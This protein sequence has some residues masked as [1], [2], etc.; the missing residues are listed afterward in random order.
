MGL[1]SKIFKPFKKIVR[2][3]GGAIKSVG[4]IIAKPLKAV[5]KPIGKFFGKLGPIGTIALGFLLPGIGGVMGSWLQGAGSAFQGLFQGMPK[6]FNAI[7]KIGN[8]IQSAAKWGGDLYGKTVG[9]VFDSIS[10]AIKGGVDWL[11]NGKATD[12]GNWCKTFTEK[13]SYKG[14]GFQKLNAD[15]TLSAFNDVTDA[16]V[17]AT[18]SLT[19]EPVEVTAQYRRPEG[20]SDADFTTYKP[21]AESLEAGRVANLESVKGPIREG[22][23][24]VTDK[25][26]AVQSSTAGKAYDVYSTVSSYLP[27]DP[28]RMRMPGTQGA[29]AFSMLGNMP[30]AFGSSDN[31][32][33]MDTNQFNNSSTF[34]ELLGKYAGGFG[35]TLTPRME[36]PFG[37]VNGL[38]GYAYTPEDAVMSGSGGN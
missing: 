32:M 4:K 6:I 9:H 22:V 1:L 8:A 16:A 7:G 38:G 37:F 18:K 15:G 11:T 5:L 35:A 20:M 29:S 21:S 24:W 31:F 19:I 27:S 30:T 34:L 17:E 33:T 36:N 12:F 14:E 3:V 26:K 10:G 2:K 28:S 23:D 13:I 25:I